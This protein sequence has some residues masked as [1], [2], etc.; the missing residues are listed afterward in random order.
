MREYPELVCLMTDGAQ[1]CAK[2]NSK[3]QVLA[4]QRAYEPRNF[5]QKKLTIS[6]VMLLELLWATK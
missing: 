5:L 3:G 1:I 4:Y 2:S 6:N